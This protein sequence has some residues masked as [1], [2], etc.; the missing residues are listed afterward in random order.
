M[1]TI[2]ITA[3]LIAGLT[4]SACL[5]I[6]GDNRTGAERYVDAGTDSKHLSQLVARV[7]VDPN[8]CDHWII[9][10][11]V[12]EYMSGRMTPDGRPICSGV[13]PPNTA[14]GPFREGSDI[15]DTL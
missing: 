14:V 9:D 7:W 5:N 1:K 2:K 15:P 4:L 6:E 8:G 13:A 12:E 10:D 11:G 3:L